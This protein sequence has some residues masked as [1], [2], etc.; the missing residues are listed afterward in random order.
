MSSADYEVMESQKSIEWVIQVEEK[1]AE[2][3]TDESID[4]Y[5]EDQ[6]ETV[7]EGTQN[8]EE[9]T[10]D[11][12]EEMMKDPNKAADYITEQL[13]KSLLVVNPHDL[14]KDQRVFPERQIS[15][16]AYQKKYPFIE[17]NYEKY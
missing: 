2:V 14:E 4:D 7:T 9:E 5:S 1:K 13:I 8:V 3:E 15:M 10:I 17:P 11:E 16:K 12:F 6:F